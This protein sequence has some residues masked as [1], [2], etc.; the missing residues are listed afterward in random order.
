MS[1]LSYE[2][3]SYVVQDET[4]LRGRIVFTIPVESFLSVDATS[5][6]FCHL[7]LP[8][9]DGHHVHRLSDCEFRDLSGVVWRVAGAPQQC[10]AILQD[11]NE[12]LRRELNARRRHYLALFHQ[13]ETPA[14]PDQTRGALAMKSLQLSIFYGFA[15]PL[16]L[17]C[18]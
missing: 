6:K 2:R 1:Q 7:P 11:I 10:I 3:T 17:T 9:M 14:W 18:V 5:G 13:P 12:L 16:A 4:G 8:S 15:F